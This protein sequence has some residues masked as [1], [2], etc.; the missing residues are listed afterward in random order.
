MTDREDH[1][2][3]HPPSTRFLQAASSKQTHPFGPWEVARES[4]SRKGMFWSSQGKAK[5]LQSLSTF[6]HFALQEENMIYGQNKSLT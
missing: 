6:L 2:N 5:Y 1:V 3:K 4:A